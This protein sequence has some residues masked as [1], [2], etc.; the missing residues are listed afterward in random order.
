MEVLRFVDVVVVVVTVKFRDLSPQTESESTKRH[1]VVLR[2]CH[3]VAGASCQD[4]P[5]PLALGL[6]LPLSGG[7]LS[8]IASSLAKNEEPAA[9]GRGRAVASTSTSPRLS[10]WALRE[11]FILKCLARL[12]A[13]RLS[14]C[15]LTTHTPART[16]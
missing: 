7:L 6:A 3:R 9:E 10:T 5:Y 8:M 13:A 12:P 1:Q 15:R 16:S 2:L 14:C 11:L 4:A